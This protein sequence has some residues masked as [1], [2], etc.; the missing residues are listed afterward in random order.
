MRLRD[1]LRV[2]LLAIPL[3]F[4]APPDVAAD[5]QIPGM[6]CKGG[7][8]TGSGGMKNNDKSKRKQVTCAI[9]RTFIT[10]TNGATVSYSLTRSNRTSKNTS[11]TLTSHFQEG[12]VDATSATDVFT[13]G[14]G[15]ALDT[16]SVFSSDGTQWAGHYLLKCMLAPKWVLD[17]LTLDE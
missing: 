11:C 3:A 2:S 14:S 9:P 12:S 10:D 15:N 5:I 6:M 16:L 8:T 4:V 7:K 17:S 13:A 1:G